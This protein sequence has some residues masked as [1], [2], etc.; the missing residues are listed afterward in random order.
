MHKIL[1]VEDNELNLDMLS[2][3]LARKGFEVLCAVNGKEALEITLRES[4]EIIL[5]DLGL[6]DLDGISV[7]NILKSHE[8]TKSI[9]VIA[10][11][12]FATEADKEHT[13]ATGFSDFEPKPIQISRLIEKINIL[14]EGTKQS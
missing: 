7:T 4:P 10:V 13:L 5:M 2:R 3:R 8:S 11:T 14:L 9:P 12:A 1:V 6:P